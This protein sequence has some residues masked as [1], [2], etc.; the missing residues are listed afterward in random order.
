[1]KI[2]KDTV[3]EERFFFYY[4]VI[5]LENWSVKHFR[6]TLFDWTTLY[7]QTSMTNFLLYLLV[8]FIEKSSGLFEQHYIK[9]TGSYTS[10]LLSLRSSITRA[11]ARDIY[12]ISHLDLWLGRILIHLSNDGAD[13]GKV[14][15]FPNAS[16]FYRT[17]FHLNWNTLVQISYSYS[18]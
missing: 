4:K 18:F 17:G 13:F 8:E 2:K 10:N 3:W 15:Q 14:M 11:T 16:T 6:N 5:I 7:T 1:M 9:L 12:G